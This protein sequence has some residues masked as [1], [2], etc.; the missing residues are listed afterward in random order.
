MYRGG[1]ATF[2]GWRRN[3]GLIL[4]QAPG[5][6]ASWAAAALLPAL[7]ATAALATGA[8]AA[9]LIAWCGGAAGSILL[10]LDSGSAPLWGL[11]Y[12]LDG[13]TLTACLAT[14]AVDRSRGARPRWRGRP[15]AGDDQ[16]PSGAA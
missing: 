11:L 3:L 1:R 7:L 2:R 8:P 9:A 16:P 6:A 14:V 13:L 10:R 4:E 5:R 15:L 12:P